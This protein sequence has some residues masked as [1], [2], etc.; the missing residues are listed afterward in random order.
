MLLL[1]PHVDHQA[2]VC[3]SA[4]SATLFFPFAIL[5]LLGWKELVKGPNVLGSLS[6]YHNLLHITQAHL[7]LRWFPVSPTQV[8]RSS[9]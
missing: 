2:T 4:G 6:Q 1:L 7:S 8:I 9:T 5:L 3:S